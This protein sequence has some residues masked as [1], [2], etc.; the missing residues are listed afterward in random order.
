MYPVPSRIVPAWLPGR[1]RAGPDSWPGPAPPAAR[2]P[3]GQSSPIRLN[4][5]RSAA[6][7]RAT[8]ARRHRRVV[9]PGLRR[10]RPGDPAVLVRGLPGQC[11]A[12]AR[13]AAGPSAARGGRG[14]GQPARRVRRVRAARGQRAGFHQLPAARR[15]D[16]RP[17]LAHARRPPAG[18]G[19]RG[20]A[21]D[22]GGGVLLA[23]HRQGDAR[24]AP[25]HDR[26]RGR[27][28]ARAGVR[29]PPR[30]QGQPRRR[31]GH[32]VRHA[33]RV[34]A[35]RGRG[36]A[37]G[38]AAAHRPERVLPGRP[39]Q[40]RFRPGIRGPGQETRGGPAGRRPGHLA[41]LARD[42]RPVHGLPAPHLRPPAGHAHRRRHQGRELLQRPAGRHRGPAGRR[43]PRGVQRRRAVRV[44]A[45]LHRPGGAAA[46]GHHPQAGRRL[47]LLHHRPGHHPVPGRR[48]ALRPRHLR[49]RL[50]PDPALPDGLRGG[51][52]GGVDPAGGTVRARPGRP[53]LRAR[54][55]PAAHQVR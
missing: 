47:Q 16:R 18:P 50:G 29:R 7:S 23:Q 22:G 20:P 51:P 5:G 8:G 11:G 24:R 1:G 41:A 39:A 26:R 15:V 19:A 38:G 6:G 53:G 21:A 34:P 10:R 31:L 27:R 4:H 42:H 43:G 17:G 52:G 25:A 30:D 45:R 3:R 44:P 35:R 14:A 48:A 12:P 40:V 13:Q 46:A 49:G 2:D 32:P 9:R 28:R 36:L 37:R 33:D 55:R 54:R